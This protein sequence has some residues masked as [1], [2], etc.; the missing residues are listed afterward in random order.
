MLSAGET[1]GATTLPLLQSTLTCP[2][3]GRR[4]VDN[5]PE[6]SWVIAYQCAGCD[7]L[8]QPAESDCCVYCTYGLAPCPIMQPNATTG[9]MNPAV[10]AGPLP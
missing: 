8:M 9:A 10:G 5:R 1:W 7:V 3:C 2:H 4:R 6:Q